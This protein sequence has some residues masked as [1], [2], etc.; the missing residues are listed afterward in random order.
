ML[1]A[2]AL[3]G[4]L[5]LKGGAAKKLLWQGFPKDTYMMT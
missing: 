3:Q 5:C 4:E 1:M 2:T